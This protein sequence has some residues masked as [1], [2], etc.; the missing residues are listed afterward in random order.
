[1]ITLVVIF[2]LLVLGLLSAAVGYAVWEWQ[3]ARSE[4]RLT[5]W[6]AEVRAVPTSERR[7]A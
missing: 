3:D 7:A 2:N 5:Q 6:V 4:R 1:M